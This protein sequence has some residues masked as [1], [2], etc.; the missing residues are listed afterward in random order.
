MHNL[1]IS[2][3]MLILKIVDPLARA[4][5]KPILIRHKH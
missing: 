2:S 1:I 5:G 4:L 3:L